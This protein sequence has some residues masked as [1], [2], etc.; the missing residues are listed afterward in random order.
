[1]EAGQGGEGLPAQ[2]CQEQPYCQREEGKVW[3]L[4][5]LCSR[6]HLA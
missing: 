2:C 6:D 3:N 5:R 1:M 4:P